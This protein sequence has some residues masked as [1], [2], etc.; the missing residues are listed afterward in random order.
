MIINFT[1]VYF[2]KI[3]KIFSKSEEQ[4]KVKSYIKLEGTSKYP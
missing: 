1:L 4:K 2:L 3:I